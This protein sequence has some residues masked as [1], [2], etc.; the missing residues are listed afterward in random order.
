[1][2]ASHRLLNDEMLVTVD[3]RHTTPHGFGPRAVWRGDHV[4]VRQLV[5]DFARYIYLP[6]LQQPSVL[7][8]AI[9]DGVSQL[10][11]TQD[12]FAFGDGYDEEKERYPGLR[13]GQG[14]FIDETSTGLIVVPDVAQRQMDREIVVIH[15]TRVQ[16][17]ALGQAKA[18]HGPRYW[19]C[20]PYRHERGN[21]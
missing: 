12:S 3:G 19:N 17:M 4:S 11:W 10:T 6:R 9:R 15:R 18:R 14:L 13:A 5:D 1:M 8:D 21:R 7:L 20:R 2:L 16:T